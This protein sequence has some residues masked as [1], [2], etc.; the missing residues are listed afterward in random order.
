MLS[1]DTSV[2]SDQ[3]PPWASAL[4]GR[5]RGQN[6]GFDLGVRDNLLQVLSQ[7]VGQFR[8]GGILHTHSL[9]QT[10]TLLEERKP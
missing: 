6:C 3:Q 2:R 7:L 9:D 8:A 5:N 4:V 1:E 10:Q